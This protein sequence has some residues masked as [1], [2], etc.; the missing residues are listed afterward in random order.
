M[1][2]FGH[3]KCLSHT[4]DPLRCGF[5]LMMILITALSA[6]DFSSSWLSSHF[7]NN[8]VDSLPHDFLSRARE[9][10]KQRP[11]SRCSAAGYCSSPLSPWVTPSTLQPQLSPLRKCFRIYISSRPEF[12]A[13]F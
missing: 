12:P 7:C 2:S 1:T 4:P 5:S 10:L 3:V 13:A 9:F 6:P 11:S 8:F